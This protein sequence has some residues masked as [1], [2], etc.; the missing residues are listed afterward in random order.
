MRKQPA[1]ETT[2][3]SRVAVLS[4]SPVQDDRSSVQSILSHSNWRLYD[5]DRLASA[6][7]ILRENDIGVVLCECD[8]EPGTWI[9]ML[10]RLRYLRDAPALIVTTRQ[11]DDQLWAEALRLGAY[12]VLAKPFDQ[13]GLMSSISRAWQHWLRQHENR[14]QTMRARAAS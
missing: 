14:P 2:S 6:L 10:E 5:A 4:V 3:A 13:R 1:F 12:D 11:A 9:D 7:A 8:L